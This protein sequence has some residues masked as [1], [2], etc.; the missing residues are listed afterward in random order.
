MF[1]ERLMVRGKRLDISEWVT[2]YYQFGV[3]SAGSLDMITVPPKDPDTMQQTFGVDLESIEQCT[4]MYDKNDRLIFEGDLLRIDCKDIH[5]IA[6]VMYIRGSFVC[7]RD[8]IMS[9]LLGDFSKYDLEIVGNMHDNPE[10]IGEDGE[11]EREECGVIDRLT[12]RAGNVVGYCGQHNPFG[13]VPMTAAEMTMT[14]VYP[15]GDAAIREVL[16][17]LADYEDT[18]LS[19]ERCAELAEAERRGR[20]FA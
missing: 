16:N 4:A 3:S 6:P 2:G 12:F 7:G 10:L 1:R 18:G 9:E 13:H 15:A 14:D 19:P 20:K 11:A 17:R 5:G 8:Y